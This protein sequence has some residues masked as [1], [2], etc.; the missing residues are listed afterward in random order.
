MRTDERNKS[1]DELAQYMPCKEEED[2]RSTKITS[3]KVNGYAPEK[4]PSHF[5]FWKVN[6]YA[7]E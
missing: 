3:I 4:V 7:P 2:Q 6:G 1:R 5:Q